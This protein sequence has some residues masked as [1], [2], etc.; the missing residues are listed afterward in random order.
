MTIRF[1][2]TL[3]ML[4]HPLLYVTNFILPLFIVWKSY[5]QKIMAK[6][7]QWKLNK[8]SILKGLPMIM[9]TTT[10]EIVE[11]FHIFFAKAIRYVVLHGMSCIL[12]FL[13][14]L[15]LLC[16][17]GHLRSRKVMGRRRRLERFQTPKTLKLR[18]VPGAPSNRKH[19]YWLVQ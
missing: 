2:I 9:L 11:L 7:D 12:L 17:S 19:R 3:F 6:L 16:Y 8:I 18:W 1:Y 10:L 15:V 14:V 5:C 4:L 13:S